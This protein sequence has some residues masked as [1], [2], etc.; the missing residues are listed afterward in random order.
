[1]EIYIKE[2]S[3]IVWVFNLSL[4]PGTR[5]WFIFKFMEFIKADIPVL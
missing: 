5:P 1:M 4:L 2:G 3:L